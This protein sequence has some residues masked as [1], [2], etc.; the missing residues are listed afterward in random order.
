M[1]EERLITVSGASNLGQ[2]T[3][4]VVMIFF[5]FIQQKERELCTDGIAG[6]DFTPTARHASIT[7]RRH[8]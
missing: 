5:I 7:V 6:S 2:A 1:T 8:D 3:A 4:V